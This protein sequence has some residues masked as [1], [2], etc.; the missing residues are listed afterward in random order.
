LRNINTSNIQ[1]WNYLNEIVQHKPFGTTDVKK[2][3]ARLQCKV[4]SQVWDDRHPESGVISE[5]AVSGSP[6]TVKEINI[7]TAC[8]FPISF[9]LALCSGL[10]V[11][12]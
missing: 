1:F 5:T 3:V 9:G 11:P 4:F 6:V 8:D 10:Y 12:I 2:R 7:E